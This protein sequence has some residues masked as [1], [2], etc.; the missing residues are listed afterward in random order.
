M[1]AGDIAH[2]HPVIIDDEDTSESL[3]LKLKSESQIALSEFISK[4]LHNKV[5]Y[6]QQD[7]SKASFAPTISKKDGYVD[8]KKV[9]SSTLK[10][11]FRAF[12]PW[13]GLYFYLNETRI[14]ILEVT[15]SETNLPAGKLNLDFGGLNIGCIDGSVR[16]TKVQAEGKKPNSDIELINSFKNK[17]G[18]LKITDKD[19]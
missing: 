15:T 8:F 17:F 11:M 7:H 18:E 3:F 1:D 2:T 12:Y 4:L 9:S 13:P 5:S 19:I 16:L 6:V 10:N 14:K